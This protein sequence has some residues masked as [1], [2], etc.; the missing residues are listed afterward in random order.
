MNWRQA[1]AERRHDDRPQH[2]ANRILRAFGVTAP[3]IQI[4]D[5]VTRPGIRAGNVPLDW[6]HATVIGRTLELADTK[7]G[8][9]VTARI[10]DA[11]DFDRYVA[12][13]E[14]G[15]AVELIAQALGVEVVE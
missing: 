6:E 12:M 4:E 5:I 15:T 9:E 8:I 13:I 7:T 10:T 14:D 3:P 11:R 1:R 2:V